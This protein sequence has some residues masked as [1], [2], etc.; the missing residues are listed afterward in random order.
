[1]PDRFDAHGTFSAARA[2]KPA[3]KFFEGFHIGSVAQFV[4]C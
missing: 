2:A 4:G 1:M 3:L